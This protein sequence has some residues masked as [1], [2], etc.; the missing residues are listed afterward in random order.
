MTDFKTLYSRAATGSPRRLA[1]ACAQDEEVLRA[2]AKAEELG[3]AEG[4]LIGERSEILRVAEAI[5]YAPEDDR[6]ED[7]TDPTAAAERAVKMVAR[8]D[9]AVLM[10]GMVDTSVVMRA[11]LNA[12][13]GLRGLRVLSHVALF[14]VPS[15]P[16]LLFLSDAAMNIAPDLD[17]KKEIIQNAVEVAHGVGLENPNVAVLCAKEKVDPKMGATLDA[18][19]LTEMNRAG[20]I[21]GCTVGGPFALDNAISPEAA[22]HKGVTHPGAGE[23]DILIAP[24]LEAGNILYKA[25]AFL[26]GARN[27]G[28]IVGAK[29]PIVLTSRADSEETKLNSI[30]L[31]VMA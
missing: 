1:V 4:V 20:Q 16:R 2:V 5:G 10:K 8:G 19:R 14:E 25:L 12:H 17:Q 15:Y 30:A 27:A 24:N 13:W 7:V 29:K 31:A 23:A 3:I 28:I 11:A 21:R 6:I 26:A 22:R 18:E 9:A